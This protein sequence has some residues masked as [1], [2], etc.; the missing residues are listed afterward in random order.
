MSRLR[1]MRALLLALG[2]AGCAPHL[3][4]STSA[5]GLSDQSQATQ[6]F[7]QAKVFE[8][9]DNHLGAIVALRSAADLDPT[10][11]TIF[12]QLARNY[13]QIGDHR[14]A[15]TY[16]EKSLQ[17]DADQSGLRLRL[18]RWYD[19]LGDAAASARHVEILIEQDPHNWQ[20]YSHLSRLYMAIGKQDQIDDLFDRLLKAP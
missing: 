3:S 6:Y 14:M 12:A 1:M 5:K 15:T 11:P 20:L 8:E 4:R 10:S 9:Q 7:I 17:L 2:L 16:A 18:V 19:G 13:R